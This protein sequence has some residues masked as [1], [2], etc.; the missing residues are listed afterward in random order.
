MIATWSSADALIEEQQR[1]GH[2]RPDPWH[3]DGPEL[4]ATGCFVAFHRGEA[5]PGAAGDRA[6]VGA[7]TLSGTRSHAEAVVAGVAGAAYEPGL[8]ARREGQMLVDALSAVLDAG[9]RPDVLLVDATGRDHPRR[10]GLAVHLGWLLDLPTV[11]VTHRLLTTRR[12][13]PVLTR[14]GDTH[15]VVLDG[16]EVAAWVCTRDDVRPLVAHAAWRTDA[17]TAASVAVRTA[18]R[19]RTP[20]PLRRARELART[21]REVAG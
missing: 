9:P 3:H 2:L 21:A 8:L 1:V 6:W 18:V 4:V 15:P 14:A 11:G 17:A 19:A 5:G 10:C 7:A 13:P 20:E 16:E 12:D